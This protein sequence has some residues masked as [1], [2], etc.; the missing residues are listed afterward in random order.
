MRAAWLAGLGRASSSASSR[1]VSTLSADWHTTRAVLQ[2]SFGDGLSTLGTTSYPLVAADPL[3][4]CEAMVNATAVAGA[5]VLVERGVRQGRGWVV[6]S[7][8]IEKGRL[9]CVVSS[10]RPSLSSRLLCNLQW[11]Q[12]SALFTP[13]H[14]GTCALASKVQNAQTAGAAAALIF[15]NVLGGYFVSAANGSLANSECLGKGVWVRRGPPRGGLLYGTSV[16]SYRVHREPAMKAEV[17]Y[18][19]PFPD[20]LPIS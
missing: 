17:V 20:S 15:D 2:G 5:I 14:A 6:G 12:P 1:R 7:W 10:T 16:L 11:P 8:R 18:T 13:H 3:L 19:C 4:A 9:F